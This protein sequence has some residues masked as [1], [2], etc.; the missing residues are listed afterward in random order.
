LAEQQYRAIISEGDQLDPPGPLLIAD[1]K[2]HLA[3]L[4][5]YQP[6]RLD[7][8]DFNS[9][10]KSPSI[11]LFTEVIETRERLLGPR[12]RS[13]GLAYAGLAA[14]G[15]CFSD[16]PI[17]DQ[18]VA[19]HAIE[20]LNATKHESALVNFL[21]TYQRAEHLRIQGHSAEAEKLYLQLK[22]TISKQVG[23]QHPL[24][25]VHLWNMVGHYC[26]FLQFD[27]AEA[28][29]DELRVEVK[30]LVHLRSTPF[31][32]DALC[33][34]AEALTRVNEAKAREVSDEVIRY[35]N[36]RPIDCK[37]F[38]QRAENVLKQIG[39]APITSDSADLPSAF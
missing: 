12:D 33:Q 6:L 4:L 1:A 2:Y 38:R 11:Q 9:Q 27:R 3:W 35:A 31:H 19:A 36:E 37:N 25:V 17:L 34:Y 28:T 16:K 23:K 24:Y 15:M 32:L 21:I 20:I 39:G 7:P 13:V 18:T 8:Q 22:E 14:A 30:P 5:I 26:K 10:S 29:I